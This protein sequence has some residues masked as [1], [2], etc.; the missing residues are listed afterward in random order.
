MNKIILTLLTSLFLISPA[1]ALE[2]IP[3]DVPKGSI[4]NYL[5]KNNKQ[6]VVFF[7]YPLSRISARFD[8]SFQKWAESNPSNYNLYRIVLSDL[9][10]PLAL[11]YNVQSSP[12]LIIF[13]RNQNIVSEGRQAYSTIFK[14]LP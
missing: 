2:E 4:E 3:E 5:A 10:A 11:E 9:K 1:L 8:S 6:S 7:H 14:Q 12:Y 13:D